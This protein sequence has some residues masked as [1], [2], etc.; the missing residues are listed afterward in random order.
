M[1][2]QCLDP[3][4]TRSERWGQ[5]LVLTW[6]VLMNEQDLHGDLRHW[7]RRGGQHVHLDHPCQAAK[8]MLAAFL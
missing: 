5:M 2:A 8:H 3:V 1:Q 4:T 7:S 6:K